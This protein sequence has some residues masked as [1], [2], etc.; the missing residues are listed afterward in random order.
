MGGGSLVHGL[1]SGREGRST[2]DPSQPPAGEGH[3]ALHTAE[4]SGSRRGPRTAAGHVFR[5]RQVCP[6]FS[7]QEKMSVLFHLMLM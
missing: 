4:G 3:T 7:S 2:V 1:G 6:R 5:R